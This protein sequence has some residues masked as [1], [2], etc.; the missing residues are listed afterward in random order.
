MAANGWWSSDL[1]D[2]M[3]VF[4][5]RHAFEEYPENMAPKFPMASQLIPGNGSLFPKIGIPLP[6]G[7]RLFRIISAVTQATEHE[8]I[9]ARKA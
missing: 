9:L 6:G 3:Q 2:S 7:A 4:N 8:I 1:L 5:S